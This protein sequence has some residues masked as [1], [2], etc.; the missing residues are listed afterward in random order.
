V[1][2]TCIISRRDTV[3]TED[4]H[5]SVVLDMITNAMVALNTGR[6]ADDI[7]CDHLARAL[8]ARSGVVISLSPDGPPHVV[9]AHPDP[10][11][12][13]SLARHL[14]SMD[15]AGQHEHCRIVSMAGHGQVVLVAI[16]AEHSETDDN[17]GRLLAFARDEPFSLDDRFL[18]ERACTSL[19]ALWPHAA[20]AYRAWQAQAWARA[21]AASNRM[22][23]RELEVL[24]LLADGLLATS[25][26]SRLRLSPRTVHKHLGNI[27]RKLGVHDRL[28]AVS[29]ARVQG[30][31]DTRPSSPL[32]P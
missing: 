15:P 7:V 16:R 27:Y 1:T 11:G 30:L 26:A 22:T 4:A 19:R 5:A 24:A 18:L 28:V 14:L 13:A 20:R 32:S 9:G 25:I 21:T 8:R 12:C 3:V 23:D 6:L 31:V 17:Y 2:E 10:E 29:L